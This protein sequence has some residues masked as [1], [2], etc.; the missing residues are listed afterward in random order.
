MTEVVHHRTRGLQ[1]ILCSHNMEIFPSGIRNHSMHKPPARFLNG[2]NANNKVNR[3][4]LELATCNIKFKWISGACKKAVDCLSRLVELPQDRPVTVN[5]LCATNL[6]GPASNT[7]GRTAW[8]TSAE[9]TTLQ[10]QSDNV[11]PH[12]T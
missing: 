4:G 12:V 7:R 1:C 6:D 9:D 8:C 11:T 10:P 3:W 2:K 5:M